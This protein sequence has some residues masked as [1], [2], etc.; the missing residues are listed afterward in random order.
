[1]TLGK[2]IDHYHSL[3]SEAWSLTTSKRE[4]LVFGVFASILSMGVTLRAVLN[5]SLS[6]RPVSSIQE[7]I[8]YLASQEFGM[9][10]PILTWLEAGGSER[11]ILLALLLLVV[12]TTGLFVGGMGIQSLIYGVGASGTKRPT[13]YELVERVEWITSF[14]LVVIHLIRRVLT[15]LVVGI[16][17]L[18]I[19]FFLEVIPSSDIL[20]FVAFFGLTLP[21]VFA[22]QTIA[23]IASFHT[24]KQRQGVLRAFVEGTRLFLANWIVFLEYAVFLF[25]VNALFF[26]L[27]F[28]SYVIGLSFVALLSTLL[29]GVSPII[30]S[31]F[32][33]FF[34]LLGILVFLLLLGLVTL[35]NYAT[36]HLLL[37]RIEGG[38]IATAVHVV[39]RTL[40]RS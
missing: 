15:A 39:L 9:F 4:L 1:M 36:W 31:L 24:V 16:G 29:S 7:T 35:F 17:I 38:P 25:V 28:G 10:K 8:T 27:S 6:L 18:G 14:H 12:I 30:A 34:M 26:L 2:T 3:V 11:F 33:G 23:M 19:S 21:F 22:F 37:R 13:L 40:G 5:A 20:L 32:A